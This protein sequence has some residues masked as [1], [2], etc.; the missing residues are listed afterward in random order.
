MMREG[1]TDPA[2]GAEERLTAAF[3]PG[4]P[5]LHKLVERLRVGVLLQGPRAEVVYANRAALE[6]LGLT[7]SQI[8]GKTPFDAAAQAVREDGSPLPGGD[9]P[10][11]RALATGRAVREM[12]VGFH[13]P[14]AP[15][16]T[17]FLVDAEP[18]TGPD[19]Q[20]QALCTF[21]D[22]TDRRRTLER[23]RES[24]TRY[25]QLVEKAHDIIYRTDV[26]GF[27][28]YVNPA[29]SRHVGYPE[30]ELIGKHFRELIRP[31]QRDRVEAGLVRQFQ[32]HVPSTYDEF[33]VVA[34][35]GRELWMGQHVELLLDGGR[36]QGFQAVARDITDRRQAEEA[37]EREADLRRR[38]AEITARLSSEFLSGLGESVRTPLNGIIGMTRLLLQGEMSSPQRELAGRIHHAGRNLLATVDHM[39]EFAHLEAG[40]LELASLELDPRALVERAAAVAEKAAREKRVSL[41]CSI[42]EDLPSRLRGD[43]TRLQQILGHLLSNAVRF[44]ERG[45]IDVGVDLLERSDEEVV[46][47]FAVTDSGVGV[48]PE[49]KSHLFEP[50]PHRDG[51]LLRPGAGSGLGLAVC[52]RLAEAMGGEVG[53]NSEPGRGATFWFTARLERPLTFVEPVATATGPRRVLVVEDE[54]VNLNVLVALL[55]NLGYQVDAVANGLDAVDACERVRYD[56]VLMDCQLPQMDG[57]RATAWIRQRESTE[58]HTPIIALTGADEPGDRERCLAAG[59]DDHLGKPVRL[60]NLDAALRKWTRG[61]APAAAETPAA[62]GLSSLLPDD[63]PLRM[64]EAQGMASVVVEIIDLFLQTTPLRFAQMRD[65]WQSG[66][67]AELVAIAHNLKSAAGELGAMRLVELCGQIQAVAGAGAIAACDGLIDALEVDYESVKRSLREEKQRLAPRSETA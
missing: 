50:F 49:V 23:L 52:K 42:A 20:A 15:E 56:A 45:T 4:S 21:I 38:E 54:L 57:Y 24:E 53:V 39:L 67:A 41:R 6:L 43:A 1:E 7:E 29:A 30:A 16:P 32:D 10:G 63:H 59:M 66:N 27:F 62:A 40:R 51:S 25:R 64:L 31:D 34:R 22:I 58:W 13:R 44:T 47:R 48:R 9:H 55:Q 36:V 17:W 26:R 19:G 65:A 2:A 37:L 46:V 3:T 14:G 35:D 5:G 12:V 18:V 61:A 11:P 33:V 28:T 8:L 60:Q